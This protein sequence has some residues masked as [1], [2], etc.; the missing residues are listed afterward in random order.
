MESEKLQAQVMEMPYRGDGA[1]MVVLLPRKG[2]KAKALDKMIRRLKP[3][4]LESELKAMP[5]VMLTVK[6]PKFSVE[7]TLK[8][9][10]ITV[11]LN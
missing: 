10:L 6:F 7:S 3:E 2:T 4:A 11:R 1:S 5:S 9:E 8:D